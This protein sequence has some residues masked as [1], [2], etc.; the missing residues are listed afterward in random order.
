MLNFIL[1]IFSIS[2][3]KAAMP[4]L[5]ALGIFLTA[6]LPSFASDAF[7]VGC[8]H[9]KQGKFPLAKAFFVKAVQDEPTSIAAHYQLANT[10]F[11]MGEYDNSLFQYNACLKLNPDARMRAFCVGA[12]AQIQN[13]KRTQAQKVA[14]SGTASPANVK[15]Y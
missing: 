12:M 3:N 4:L 5:A 6:S 10:F 2:P 7:T 9:Y 13:L 8:N 14:S 15:Q 1:S 11:Q